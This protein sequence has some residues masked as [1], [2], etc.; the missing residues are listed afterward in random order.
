M[1]DKVIF[2]SFALLFFFVPLFWTPLNYE[3]FEY[4][5]MIAVYI[6]T[7][8]IVG[9]WIYKSIKARTLN[10]KR[11]PLDIPLLL[12][13]LANILST[14]FSIDQHISIFGYYSRSNGGL[15]STISYL[16]LYFAFVSNIKREQALNLLKIGVISGAV[17]AFVGNNG[18]FRCFTLL[19]YPKRR[20]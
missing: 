9:T 8:V 11:T 17:I 19:Y 10:L 13:L 15:L 3:L 4:N 5:K 2:Y 6:L 7:I 16:L 14:I 1:L 12:F 20:I 18:T